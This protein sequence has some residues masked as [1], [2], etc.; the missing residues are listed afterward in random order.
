MASCTNSVTRNFSPFLLRLTP[1]FYDFLLS[2][3]FLLTFEWSRVHAP[4]PKYL[5]SLTLRLYFRTPPAYFLFFIHIFSDEIFFSGRHPPLLST[6]TYLSTHLLYPSYQGSLKTRPSV[7]LNADCGQS[8]MKS[9][10]MFG[11]LQLI[12]VTYASDP[13]TV[14]VFFSL[15]QKSFLFFFFLLLFFFCLKMHCHP[16]WRTHV[17]PLKSIKIT[18]VKDFYL[19]LV[20]CIVLLGFNRPFC[21]VHISLLSLQSILSVHLSLHSPFVSPSYHTNGIPSYHIHTLH[22]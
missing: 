17:H 11:I 18:N 5:S 12:L 22:V 13:S 6:S 3:T 8:D 21:F 20:L 9:G 4:F 7:I 16:S 2:S 15:H 1:V 19:P 14:F 10:T